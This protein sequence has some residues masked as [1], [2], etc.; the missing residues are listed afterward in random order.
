MILLHLLKLLKEQDGKK[1]VLKS[2]ASVILA[3]GMLPSNAPGETLCEAAAAV[4]VIGDARK[5]QD[6][7]T[8]VHAGYALAQKY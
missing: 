5:V 4:E 7:F 3:S 6:I 1:I 2:F 8:A